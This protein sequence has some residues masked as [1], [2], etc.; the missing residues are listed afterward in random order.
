VEPVIQEYKA[1]EIIVLRGQIITPADFEALQ[2]FELI[3][4]ASP[5]QDYVGAGALVLMAAAFV[6]LYFS[7]RHLP[8]QYEARSLRPSDDPQPYLTA[9]CLSAGWNGIVDRHIVWR[10]NG[11]CILDHSIHPRTL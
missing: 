4:E 5:W 2:Q 8:F 1:G 6:H 3:E 11:H 9:I 7:R 10:G